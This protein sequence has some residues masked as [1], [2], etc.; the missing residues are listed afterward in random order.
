MELHF[1]SYVD[2]SIKIYGHPGYTHGVRI[3]LVINHEMVDYTNYF[4]V[5]SI[6]VK[7]QTSLGYS[8]TVARN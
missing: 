1:F 2:K 4:T 3:V 8:G 7:L 6:R 5:S